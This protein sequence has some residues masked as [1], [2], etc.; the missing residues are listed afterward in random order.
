MN[1]SV[2]LNLLKCPQC[3][4]PVP[5]EE[6]EVAWVCATCGAGLQ[7]SQTGLAPV[8]VHWAAAP[9]A[10]PVSQR[11]DGWRP[12]WVFTGSA[13][14][15]SRLSFTGQAAPEPLWNNPVR[16]FVPAYVCPLAQLQSLGADL[17]RRQPALQAGPAGTLAGCT[18]LPE[19]AE[20][21]AEFVVLTIEAA[22]PDK[23]RLVQFN[24]QLAAPE[25]WVLP[26]SG[27]Q[28]LV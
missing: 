7:L 12:F 1:S 15:S 28:L 5:A 13:H 16:F 18:F 11:V 2:T 6:D 20:Q 24:L 25:L 17:T 10:A 21:A 27:E 14:F 4:T 23:L 9:A 3:S 8:A 26:F 22:R 19:D